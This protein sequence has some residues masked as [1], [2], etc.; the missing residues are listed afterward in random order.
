MMLWMR[1]G[2]IGAIL[3]GSPPAV[4]EG[5]YL[6]MDTDG[7]GIHSSTDALRGRDVVPVDIWIRTDAGRAGPT[8][9][10]AEARGGLTIFSYEFVIRAE[11]GRVAWGEYTNHMSAMSVRFGPR[12]NDSEYY[13][14]YGGTTG[15]P[16]GRYKLGR[17]VVRVLAGSPSLSFQPRYSGWPALLTSFGSDYAGRDEDHTLKLG[18]TAEG[19][20]GVTG[21]TVGDWS[22]CDGAGAD[23]TGSIEPRKSESPLPVRFSIDAPRPA[24]PGEKAVSFRV[25]LPDR[26]RLT[27]RVFD[28]RGRLVRTVVDKEMDAGWHSLVW[29]DQTTKERPAAA[30]IYFARGEWNGKAVSRKFT[31]LR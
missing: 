1:L 28:V 9:L 18:A 29:D 22:D 16:P 21:V 3:L 24:G 25:G 14:G 17:L 2:L 11:G 30:G 4:A 12:W 31:V 20:R 26:G 23:T 7:D 5:Q 10:T 13:D 8:A 27:L 6:Y 19:G 15:L